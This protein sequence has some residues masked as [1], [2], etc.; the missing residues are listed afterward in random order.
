VLAARVIH[1]PQRFVRE[2]IRIGEGALRSRPTRSL[3]RVERADDRKVLVAWLRDTCRLPEDELVS[4][5]DIFL[6]EKFRTVSQ[7]EALQGRNREHWPE[8]L[9]KGHRVSID[10]AV[11]RTRQAPPHDDTVT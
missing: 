1:S 2:P 10:E 3:P 5:A 6:E 7:I 11:L 8:N 9:S 4:V